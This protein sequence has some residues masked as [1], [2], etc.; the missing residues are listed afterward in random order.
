MQWASKIEEKEHLKWL[1]K[2]EPDLLDVGG[3]FE[4]G[5][6]IND[7]EDADP[8]GLSRRTETLTPSKRR[9]NERDNAH[10]SSDLI[11]HQKYRV[12]YIEKCRGEARSFTQRRMEEDGNP[13]R[14]R[15]PEGGKSSIR[16]RRQVGRV[17]PGRVGLRC[18]PK[19]IKSKI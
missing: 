2:E 5:G 8:P 9:A 18:N 19:W 14:E 7:Q 1:S 11:N 3:P 13:S 17:G 16:F 6:I 10:S 4:G 12:P 15:Q